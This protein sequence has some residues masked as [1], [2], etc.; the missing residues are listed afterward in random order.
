MEQIILKYLQGK[1]SKAEKDDLLR[2]LQGSEANKAFFAE[3]RDRWLDSGAT[4]V[5]DPEYVERAFAR[6]MAEIKKENRIRNRKHFITYLKVAASIALL[7]ASS[8]ISYQVGQKQRSVPTLSVPQTIVM[9]RIITGKDNKSKV[10]LPDGTLVWLNANSQLTYPEAFAPDKRHVQLEGEGY[11]EVTR[12]EDAPFTVETGD[13][14]VNVLGTHFNVRNYTDKKEEPIE[15]TLLTGKVEINL[16][17][18]AIPLNPNQ[19]IACDKQDGS[20]QQMDVEAN[21]YILWTQDKLVFSN[22]K[23]STILHQME[24]WYHID[25]ACEAGVQLDQHLSL[26]IQRETPDEIMRLL[27]LITPIRYKIEGDRLT[28]SPK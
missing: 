26:T 28:I 16:L 6:F 24:Y 15:I 14:S 9:N 8:L 21:D 20:Y 17:G 7:L 19:V 25:I 2:W 13:V 4:P 11:F 10:S 1:A 18:N 23:L 3:T 27:A 22:D 5:A 12:N